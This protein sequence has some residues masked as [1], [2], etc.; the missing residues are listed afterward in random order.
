MGRRVLWAGGIGALA[1]TGAIVACSGSPAAPSSSGGTLLGTTPQNISSS[2]SDTIAA[3]GN[4][5][6]QNKIDICHVNENGQYKLLTLPA[7]AEPAHLGHGDAHPGDCIAALDQRLGD[8]CELLAP[9]C[10][11][12]DGGSQ[13]SSAAGS[14]GDD[15]DGDGG[16]GGGGGESQALQ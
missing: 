2:S 12:D 5:K 14:D 11:P 6:G 16:G 13:G 3:R 1:M 15:G 8:T 10:D 9:P 4:G 7:P